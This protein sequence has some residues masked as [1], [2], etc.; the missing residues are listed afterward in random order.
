MVFLRKNHDLETGGRKAEGFLILCGRANA[1]RT[2][3]TKV[4]SEGAQRGFVREERKIM[5][6]ENLHP[7]NLN[8]VAPGHD[9][10]GS[11][12]RPDRANVAAPEAHRSRPQTPIPARR[13]AG[14]KA[15]LWLFC[16]L[17][18]AGGIGYLLF[19]KPGEN[20]PPAAGS[21]VVTVGVAK[22]TRQDMYNEVPIPAEFRPYVQSQLHAIVTGYVSKMLVDFGDKVKQGQVLATL[23]APELQDE[24][25]NARANQQQAQ[26]DYDN[27]HLLYTRLQEVNQE[28]PKLVA[29]QDLDTA[30]SKDADSAAAVAAAKAKVGEF[31]TRMSYT[32]IVAPF[33]GVIT[34][35]S[36]DPGALV[37]AGTNSDRAPE[38][39]QI[40]DNYH[41]RLDFPVSVDFVQDV[42][43]GVPVKVKVD[44]LH[45][46]LF[47]GKI[48]RFQNQVNDQTRTMITEIEIDNPDL[49]IVPGMYAVVLF[50][51]AKR[52]NALAIPIEAI[53][54]PKNPTVYLVG[55]D[56]KIED[57][58]V[59]LGVEMPDKFQ[60]TK[61]LQ[62]GDL[63]MIGNRSQ[64][65]PGQ[66]VEVKI[67]GQ[68]KFE[69]PAQ[70][71]GESS[72]S[73][74]DH[75]TP[76]P[77]DPHAN[78]STPPSTIPDKP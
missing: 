31:E 16:A 36:V 1:R 42:R 19:L 38:L 69:L 49:E 29:Q 22:V 17:L 43:V 62:E 24:L 4:D 45:G 3:G 53:S 78:I 25:N 37:Q 70:T 59:T 48:S 66:Q 32:N 6:S 77:L 52:P 54:D 21:Q 67:V 41:L 55:A 7:K 72:S 12:A 35:R 8:P 18:I 61:G 34:Q 26:A 63:V 5:E 28:H 71:D 10:L 14:G 58:P 76:S 56:H 20:K 46:K 68:P 30:R 50:Q 75:S 27:E 39:L 15:W 74:A 13:H 40:S 60:V 73:Q 65:H 51:Y 23:N 2:S 11:A 33:D 64:V 9:H 44:S 57:R 47:S